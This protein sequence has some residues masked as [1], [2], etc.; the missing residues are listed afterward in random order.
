[1]QDNM[2][3]GRHSLQPSPEGDWDCPSCLPCFNFLTAPSQVPHHAWAL[4]RSVK[5]EKV[6][7]GSSQLQVRG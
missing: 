5:R 4:P 7:L 2:T 6:A 3:C 1:M